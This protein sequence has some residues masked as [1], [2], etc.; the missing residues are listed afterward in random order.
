[1]LADLPKKNVAIFISG[2]G[3]NMMA[4][5]GPG[6]NDRLDT[7]LSSKLADMART[8]ARLAAQD[9]FS[10]PLTTPR[11]ARLFGPSGGTA[12]AATAGGVQVNPGAFGSRPPP[13]DPLP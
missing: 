7:H 3:S 8:S 9:G 11:S 5:I 10:G 12:G 1:M 2:R 4:L 6:R 13:R